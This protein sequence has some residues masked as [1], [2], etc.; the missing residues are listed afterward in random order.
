MFRSPDRCTYLVSVIGATILVGPAALGKLAQ[1]QTPQSVEQRPS[2]EVASIR[3]HD[4]NDRK[5][6]DNFQT[7][8]GG[9]FT[10]DNCSPWMLLHYAFQLQPFQISGG[11]AWM[12][13]KGYDL[14]AKPAEYD[15]N[16]SD[17][18]L[19]LQRLLED[20]FKLKY[21][22]ETKQQQGYELVVMKTGKLRNSIL[23][24]ECPPSLTQQDDIPKDA[25]CGGLENSPG[26]ARGYNLTA[27]E[28]AGNLSWFLQKPI[29]DKTNLAG[30]YDV[31][32]RWTPESA[33]MRS[34]I[35][36][37]Q[38]APGIF[39]AV[40]EQLGLKLVPAKTPV[41]VLVIDHIEEPSEN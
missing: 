10:S 14:N 41:R 35:S 30:R 9:R 37:E 1:G 3:A 26:H 38:D 12:K 28:L 34:D 6:F 24:G 4:P 7:Y 8:L 23:N 31:E 16:F 29:A 11:P 33:E 36:H 15:A 39:T 27:S 2:F 5:N 19:R 40:K 18:P 21:H 22:W 25:V 20:R 13:S 17:I 32:L